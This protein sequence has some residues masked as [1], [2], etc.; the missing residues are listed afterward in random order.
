[1]HRIQRLI[2]YIHEQ[3]KSLMLFKKKRTY[4]LSTIRDRMDKFFFV[5]RK[6]EEPKINVNKN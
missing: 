1:M 5:V 4:D 2:V 3:K 6:K